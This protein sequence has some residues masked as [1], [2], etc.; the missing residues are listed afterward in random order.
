ME[1]ESFYE[2]FPRI[3][4][5]EPRDGLDINSITLDLIPI[6][7]SVGNR[8]NFP[9]E[10]TWE[11]FYH[12]QPSLYVPSGY[13]PMGDSL[14]RLGHYKE[15]Y[16]AYLET[17]NFERNR[18]DIR[19]YFISTASL[20]LNAAECNYRLD[21]KNLAWSL[22]M[23]VGVF[24]NEK[25]L[26]HVKE[27]ARFW[28]QCKENGVGLPEPEKLTKENRQEIAASIVRGYIKMNAHPRAWAFLEQHPKDFEDTVKLK[29]EVCDAWL[30]L[31]N[32]LINNAKNFDQHGIACK[33]NRL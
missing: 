8:S 21:K 22:L 31:V 16:Y 33:G 5:F 6:V 4:D 19:P 24:G 15:A 13:T 17:A 18:N 7:G 9:V 20:W 14:K 30:A 27:I 12:W 25:H 3:G 32:P 11:G 28:I 2:M 23:K 26:E 29:N 10:F 1:L